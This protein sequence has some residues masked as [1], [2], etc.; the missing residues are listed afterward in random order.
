MVF[1]EYCIISF[2]D[3]ACQLESSS[4]DDDSS[5]IAFDVCSISAMLHEVD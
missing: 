5:K 1:L 2:D 4:S 3:I